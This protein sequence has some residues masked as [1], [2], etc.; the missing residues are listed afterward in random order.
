MLP[1]KKFKYDCC[2]ILPKKCH[3]AS[4]PL[5]TQTSPLRP[6]ASLIPP[7]WKFSLSPPGYLTAA[8]IF[9]RRSTSFGYLTSESVDILPYL[10]ISHPNPADGPPHLDISHPDPA[11]VP[12]SPDIS[13][14]APTAGWERRTIQLPRTDMSGYSGDAYPD[15]LARQTL[16]IRRIH[17]RP[18]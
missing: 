3:V 2:G 10:D 13:H 4:S 11:D 15:R 7:G 9:D 16:A 17:F 12:P 18:Q 5:D 6:V 8:I 14:P 1:L